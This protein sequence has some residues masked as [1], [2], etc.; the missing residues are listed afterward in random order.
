MIVL[1]LAQMLGVNLTS[2]QQ[3]QAANTQNKP[4]VV[5]AAPQV[6]APVPTP[7]AKP[8]A[9]PIITADFKIETDDQRRD[10]LGM[11][12]NQ[13]TELKADQQNW[14]AD[15]KRPSPFVMADLGDKKMQ[16]KLGLD[17]INWVALKKENQT[18]QTAKENGQAVEKTGPLAAA[19]IRLNGGVAATA[20]P[21][22]KADTEELAP[23]AATEPTYILP[24]AA[25][26]P[27]TIAQQQP[28]YEGP[29]NDV[30][31]R[32]SFA[33]ASGI[34]EINRT[35]EDRQAY[36]N[37]GY[38]PKLAKEMVN[39]DRR[40]EMTAQGYDPRD[41]N[42]QVSQISRMADMQENQ[43]NRE[44]RQYNTAVRQANRQYERDVKE[45]SRDA[46]RIGSILS[47][48]NSRNDHRAIEIGVRQG[49]GALLGGGALSNIFSTGAR[50]NDNRVY[51]S[52]PVA[53]QRDINTWSR[54][55]GRVSG[56]LSDRNERNDYRATGIVVERGV[57]AFLRGGIPGLPGGRPAEI[58]T[59]PQIASA[60]PPAQEGFSYRSNTLVEP[61]NNS[62]SYGQTAQERLRL[63][64]ER[65]ERQQA[66]MPTEDQLPN[67]RTIFNNGFNRG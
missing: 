15:Q 18:W 62:G 52:A 42:K 64:E 34:E 30:Q 28:R 10:R 63:F 61:Y 7:I 67:N 23:A 40:N 60:R 38:A 35:L 59:A 36:R 56:I 53:S 50:G 39:M 58:Y 22:A 44:N 41:I 57:E 13:Y 19:I 17:D 46:G 51:P 1:A 54:D 55:A 25:P 65:H 37:A 26:A 6:A 33:R 31:P 12:Q 24:E 14:A 16:E 45:V 66:A 29:R 11:S 27:M 2:M 4:A 49:V 21:V 8:S 9:A 48:G 47:D 5:A 3:A 43:M 32:A 20:A